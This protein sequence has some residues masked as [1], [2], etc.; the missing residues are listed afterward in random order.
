MRIVTLIA[1]ILLGLA[2]VVFGLNGFLG[3]LNMGPMPTGLAGQFIGAL[4]QSHY[5]WVVAALQVIGGALLLVGR[6]VPLG[7][8]LLGPVIVNILLYHIFLNPAGMFNAIVVT[9]LWFIVFY[10]YRHHFSGIFSQ[11]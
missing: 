3:F 8:V 11:R 1:R 6:Y 4:A 2:F 5:F 7:L 10:A 9:V